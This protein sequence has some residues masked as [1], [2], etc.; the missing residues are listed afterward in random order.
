[1]FG[2][3]CY[4]QHLMV[5]LIVLKKHLFYNSSFQGDP[6]LLQYLVKKKGAVWSDVDQCGRTALHWAVLSQQVSPTQFHAFPSF[7]FDTVYCKQSKLDDGE[8][9]VG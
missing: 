3:D 6:V 2:L 1:M 4:C 5:R 9:T 7:N 8:F